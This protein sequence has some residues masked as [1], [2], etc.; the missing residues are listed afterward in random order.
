MNSQPEKKNN[1][2][3]IIAAV[4]I[5]LCCCCL[6]ASAV[7]YYAYNKS[8]TGQFN[9]SPSDT[10]TPIPP[11]LNETS[12]EVPS[13]N[14]D[15]GEPPTGGLGN[16]VLRGDTW[17]TLAPAAVGLG[18]DKPLGADTTIDVIE[19]PDANGR[20]V[21]HWNV[22]CQLGKKYTFEVEYILDA[23]GATFNI[24]YLP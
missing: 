1:T 19:Q 24:K 13:S 10:F 21:E 22:A 9:F 15:N 6:V 12:T 3:L 17:N 16:D 11:I 5:V 14:S 23:T 8:K 2:P 20:W 18:C 7:G 4:V